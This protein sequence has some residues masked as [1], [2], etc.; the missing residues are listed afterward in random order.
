MLSTSLLILLENASSLDE[1]KLI[2]ARMQAMRYELLD[3]QLAA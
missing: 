2:Y 1:I 3:R